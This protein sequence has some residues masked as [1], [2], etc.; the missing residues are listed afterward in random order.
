MFNTMDFFVCVSIVLILYLGVISPY[1]KSW[2]DK[3][4]NAV[5]GERE[6]KEKCNL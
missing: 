5:F 1:S 4:M 2:D 6:R 3:T